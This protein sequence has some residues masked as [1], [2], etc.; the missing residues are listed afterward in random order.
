MADFKPLKA[1]PVDL[2][3][4][5][6]DALREFEATDTVP[7]ANLPAMVGDTGSGGQSGLVPA[8]GAGDA[9]KVLSGA[10]TYVSLTAGGGSGDITGPGSSTVGNVPTYDDTSGTSLD[11]GFPVSAAAK[12]VLDDATIAAM[13]ATLDVDQAG[14]DNSTPV[15]LGGSLDYLSISGQEITPGAVDLTTDVTGALP[16]ANV[17]DAAITN[18]KL[19]N[20]AADTIKG[21]ANGAGTGAPQDLSASQVRTI[22]NV[23]DG[24]TANPNAVETDAAD[25]FSGLTE[26]VSPAS[27]DLLLIEDSAASG[28]KKKVQI[29]NLPGGG[30]GSGDV[31]GPVS[32]TAGNVPTWA[33]TSGDVLNDGF[34]VSAAAKTVLDDASIA[35][36]RATLDVDQA[37]TDNSTPVTLAGTLDYLTISGQALTRGPIDLTTDVSGAL[38]TANIAD[39][40]VTLAKVQHIATDSFLGRDT[41]LTGDVEVLSASTARGILNVEDGATA[42]QTGAEIKAA[43]EAEADTNAFTDAE[44]TKLAAI[45]GTNTGDQ[46]IT[47]TGDVTGSGSGSFAA[48]IAADAVTDAK[49]ANMS[50]HSIKA[51][52]ASTVGDPSNIVIGA[53]DIVGRIGAGNIQGI[54]SADLTE[55][56]TPAAGHFLFGWNGSGSARKFDVGDLPTGAGGDTLPVVD[57]TGVVKGSADGTK[58]LRFEVD[59]FTTATTRV[60]TPPNYDGT[61][62]TLAGTETLSNKTL[63]APVL[64]TPASGTLTNCDGL[65]TAG[66]VD[67][68]VTFAKMQAVSANVLLGNDATG[69]A[70]EEIACTPFA[71]TIIDDADAGAVR[72]TI[73]AGTGDGDAL[74]TSPL[75][76]FAA[77]TSAQLAG[78]ISDETGTGALVFANSPV[79]VTPALGTPASGVL[80]NCTSLPATALAVTSSDVLIG[81]DTASGGASEQISV[82]GGIEFTGS[83]GIQ[84]SA[85]TGDV[86]ASAGS[87]TTTIAN[88]AVT[89]AKIADGQ[90]TLAKQA[91]L[92]ADT[93]IGRATASTGVPE[94]ITCTAAG[95]ALIDD[96][97]PS[98]Q[99]ATL[100][101]GTVAVESTV[102]IA[103]G[104]T[105]QTTQTA[106][107]DALSP[108]TTKGDLIVDDGTNAIR[109]GVGADGHVLTADA[110][111]ASGVKWAAA[112]G[113]VSDGDKGDITVSGSGATWTIDS[114]A[115][116]N[117]KLADMAQATIKG[118][119]SGTGTGAPED[120]TASQVQNIL[121]P[122]ADTTGLVAGSVDSSK[123][124]RF[125]VDGFTTATTRVLTPPNY[126]GTIATLAGTETLTNKTLTSPTLT[127]PALGTP[128]SGTLTNCA[129]L[130]AGGA[131][132]ATTDVLLGR[133]T[134]GSGAGE[135]IACTSAGRALIDD[136]SP[137]DQRTTLGL[138]S[139]ATESVVPVSKGGTGQTAANAGFG[140]L[141]PATAKGDLIVHDG[142]INNRLTVGANGSVLVADSA[143][144]TGLRYKALPTL[145]R[146]VTIVNP[147]DTDDATLFYT[148]VAVTVTD[149]RS[150]ITAGTNV[151]YNIMHAATRDAGSPNSVFTSDVTETST[152]GAGHSSGFSDATIPAGS[153][154]W[155]S[156]TSISGSVTMLHATVVFTED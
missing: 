30:G 10:G 83:Q 65:P 123:V 6:Q 109:V 9:A 72:A 85:L 121:F 110:A 34:P 153:W 24:S 94:A 107:F 66:L 124:L 139:V 7:R 101:L 51:R 68:A 74:T 8:P 19:A 100:G 57:T 130:P 35:D 2:T 125:E 82:G 112:S 131:T 147:A 145:S 120:L 59:G 92:A 146:S 143:Q 40:A 20:E 36:M 12:T 106:G 88:D 16:T 14:T 102:P 37:G 4:T 53:D 60:L 11:G 48:T 155:L 47:L 119:R 33:D 5:T 75:S 28:A 76:Q 31:T 44:K 154:V 32:S 61:I 73:G 49:L 114:S 78:V 3:G 115:V 22:I 1:D 134:A 126:D 67:G 99:R 26:K 84:R 17:A 122:L 104:G 50:G 95:R 23:E 42:D 149:V 77:T 105:G 90:V 148:P 18:A 15:T 116:T 129:G 132:F 150:H 52:N 63:T 113:G 86:T 138:G 141:S 39:E 46:T 13:R 29:G 93:L 25:Q 118:R 89:T 140:A 56:G 62:A 91:N 117:A 69:T 80:T 127:T 21:R 135:E 54:T 96:A 43:Y 87:G 55:E 58:I 128:A 98:D 70:V 152:S 136:A 108:T 64:G 142:S 71:R 38:P 79:L 41:A 137:A 151:V 144:S 27:G 81:R 111:E 97:S 45:S 156:I 103:K 133:A